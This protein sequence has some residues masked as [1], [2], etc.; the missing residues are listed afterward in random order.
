LLG[1]L[2]SALLSIIRLYL[3]SVGKALGVA[4]PTL[5]GW[6]AVRHEDIAQFPAV[7][8]ILRRYKSLSE[9]LCTLY[10]VEHSRWEMFQRKR[11]PQGFWKD[12][13]NHRLFLEYVASYYKLSSEEDWG[14]V[15]YEMVIECG[16]RSLYRKY[17]SLKQALE[18]SFPDRNWTLLRPHKLPD[19]HW[20]DKHNVEQFLSS[21]EKIYH[22][23]HPSD[24]Y[25]ISRKQISAQGGHHLLVHYKGSFHCSL[26]SCLTV[27][28]GLAE[29]L[30]E[31][32]KG[33]PEWV[34]DW[35]QFSS[36]D[37]RSSQR[38]LFHA[39]QQLFPDEEVV[40]DY[41][42]EELSRIS[43]ASIQF[44]VFLPSR[45]TAIEY[46]GIHH[47]EDLPA[48]GYQDLYQRRD[49]EKHQLCQQNGIHLVVIPYYWDG[50]ESHLKF[51]IEDKGFRT[52]E[53]LLMKD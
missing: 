16:G 2:P 9:A 25:R 32:W 35:A 30:K 24:W 38:E 27:R 3:D 22:I 1:P 48:F 21:L 45:Q 37:K 7:R 12:Q 23:Q 17:A 34:W 51:L 8:G 43:G 14:Q 36:R 10:G 33:D 44:D 42:H 52:S 50:D 53:S 19:H 26:F 13:S 49:E 29:V 11:L 28:P 39:I 15:T 18:Q 20:Q 46:H 5:E 6:N 41:F 31:H 40:E 4:K 47:Y